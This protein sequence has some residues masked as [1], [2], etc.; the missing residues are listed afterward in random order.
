MRRFVGVSWV[1]VDFVLSRRRRGAS[2][3][4]DGRSS[5]ILVDTESPF[6]FSGSD[7]LRDGVVGGAFMVGAA[8]SG[9]CGVS[10]FIPV[11]CTFSFSVVV[12]SITG[13]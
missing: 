13:S 1:E 11:S 6:I 2:L 7:S 10:G 8:V 12:T 4:D 9:S 3:D 5:G